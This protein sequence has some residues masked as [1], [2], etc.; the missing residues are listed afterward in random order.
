M[1]LQP[2]AALRQPVRV[3]PQ[4]LEPVREQ[5]PELEP[6]R[7]LPRRAKALPP[8]EWSSPGFSHATLHELW[9]SHSGRRVEQSARVQGP[10]PG[11]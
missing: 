11:S 4:E 5:R 6:V 1:E 8:Q 9:Q 2:A 3:R 7:A 10:E